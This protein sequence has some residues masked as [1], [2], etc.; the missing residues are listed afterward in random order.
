MAALRIL[1]GTKLFK[2]ELAVRRL[3]N[4]VKRLGNELSSA[5]SALATANANASFARDAS[6]ATDVAVSEAIW[7]AYFQ[8]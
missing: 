6:D 8:D 1:Q 3:S 2:A 7:K 4:K 5:R